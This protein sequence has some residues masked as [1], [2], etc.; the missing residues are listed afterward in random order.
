MSWI[1]VICCAA[2]LI[3]CEYLREDRDYWRQKVQDYEDE[4]AMRAVNGRHK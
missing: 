3:A 2:L 1:L 4:Q